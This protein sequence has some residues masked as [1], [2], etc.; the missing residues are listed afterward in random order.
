MRNRQF[1]DALKVLF[2]MAEGDNS[3]DG[4]SLGHA[5]GECYEQLGDLHAARYWYVRAYQENPAIEQY[6]RD[7]DRMQKVKID[8]LLERG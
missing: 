6:R 8:D 5:I 7:F 2:W 3:L 1:R 4:G